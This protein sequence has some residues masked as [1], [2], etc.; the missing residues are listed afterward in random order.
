MA[1]RRFGR[2]VFMLSSVVLGAPPRFRTSYVSSKYALEGLM[3]S[4]SVEFAGKGVTIN[5]VAPSMIETKFLTSV[6]GI[7][8]EQTAKSNPMDRNAKVEDILPVIQMLLSDENE[9][10]TGAVIPVT[11]GS[12][13]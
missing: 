5:G 1:R 13:L 2:V 7:V 10:M 4:L 11:G 9:Y 6:P 3:K 8:V 12:V